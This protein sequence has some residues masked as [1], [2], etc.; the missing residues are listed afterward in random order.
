MRA[1]FE[2]KL[3]ISHISISMIVL[4][5]LPC[6]LDPNDDGRFGKQTCIAKKIGFVSRKR[7]VRKGTTDG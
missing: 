1:D 3:V 7:E 5:L 2:Q 6:C 4:Y